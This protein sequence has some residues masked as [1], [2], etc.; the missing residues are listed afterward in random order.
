MGSIRTLLVTALGAIAVIRA[1][2][3]A[4]AILIGLAVGALIIAL[5]LVVIVVLVIF[6]TFLDRGDRRAYS[7]PFRFLF[8][9]H[10]RKS[11][12]VCFPMAVT[13]VRGD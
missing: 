5:S 10:Y 13:A 3:I 1:G 8:F 6:A 7:R 12:C 2:L 9:F 4:F 11:L